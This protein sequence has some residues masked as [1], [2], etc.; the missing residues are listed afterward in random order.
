[1]PIQ[2]SAVS[3]PQ[4]QCSPFDILKIHHG[5]TRSYKL[6]L[7]IKILRESKSCM[8]RVDKVKAIG[9]WGPLGQREHF[10]NVSW[11]DNSV[12]DDIYRLEKVHNITLHHVSQKCSQRRLWNGSN[13]RLTDDGPF[14]S[15]QCRSSSAS[16]LRHY[17]VPTPW[18]VGTTSVPWCFSPLPGPHTVECRNN[19]CTLVLFSTTRSPHRGV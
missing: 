14:S 10:H 7:V 16:F 15:C 11:T 17:P 2:A 4:N 19:L 8:S 6:V 12:Q 18:S 13:V 9:N 1:M 3:S 5:V